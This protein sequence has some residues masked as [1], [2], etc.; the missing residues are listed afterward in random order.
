MTVDKIED[1]WAVIDPAG[2]IIA[3]FATNAAAWR[4]IDRQEGGPISRAEHV[5]EWIW[6]K[7]LER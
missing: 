5:A 6:E 2:N 3:K 4:W 7:Q 1:G